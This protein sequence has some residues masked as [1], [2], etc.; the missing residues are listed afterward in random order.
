LFAFSKQLLVV[1]ARYSKSFKNQPTI[2]NWFTQTW[3]MV[4]RAQ[5]PTPRELSQAKSNAQQ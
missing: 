2:S 3:D 4:G 5:N 1:S